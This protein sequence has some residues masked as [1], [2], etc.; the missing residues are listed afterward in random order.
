MTPLAY[1][2]G[3][4]GVAEGGFFNASVSLGIGPVSTGGLCGTASTNRGGDYWRFT[5]G[6]DKPGISKDAPLHDPSSYQNLKAGIN[7]SGGFNGTVITRVIPYFPPQPPA[8][9]PVRPVEFYI[10][11]VTPPMFHIP[12]V[13]PT[14]LSTN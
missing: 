11:N 6:V 9:P 8:P 14:S 4:I 13:T 3:V 5:A 2:T 7:F 10:P 12:N 1:P